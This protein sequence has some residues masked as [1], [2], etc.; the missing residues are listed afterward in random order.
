MTIT[1]QLMRTYGRNTADWDGRQSEEWQYLIY[2]DTGDAMTRDDILA[3]GV[4]PDFGTRITGSQMYLT[5]RTLEPESENRSKWIAEVVFETKVQEDVQSAE[6]PVNQAAKISYGTLTRDE[7][8]QFAYKTD[9]TDSQGDPTVPVW[10]SV[11]EFFDPTLIEQEVFLVVEI[12]KNYRD[13]SPENLRLFKNTVNKDG[14]SI[15]GVPAGPKVAWMM[16]MRMNPMVDP[17]GEDYDQVFYQVAFNPNTWTRKIN[18]MGYMFYDGGDAEKKRNILLS[19]IN[20]DIV[21]GSDD[22]R[23]VSVP[24]ALAAN[25]TLLKANDDP[26]K[27]SFQTKFALSWR[28]LNLPVYKHGRA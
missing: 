23:E 19:D 21:A 6:D 26:V 20:D 16:D 13:F 25:G 15:A 8:L 3:A 10:N 24:Q 28:P 4:L 14:T 5:Q 17:E 27:L 11:K 7:A 1:A 18:N 22:D 2:Q 12:T 9:D